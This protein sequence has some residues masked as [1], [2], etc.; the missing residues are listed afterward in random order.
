MNPQSRSSDAGPEPRANRAEIRCPNCQTLQFGDV[1][2][3]GY[4]EIETQPCHADDCTK[5][6]CPH[7]PQFICAWCGLAH[8]LSHRVDVSGEDVCPPCLKEDSE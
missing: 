8:C 7:C 2:E 3:D 4:V 5:R 6:L 1:D